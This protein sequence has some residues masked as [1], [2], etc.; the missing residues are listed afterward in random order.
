M[1][2]QEYLNKVFKDSESAFM[3]LPF[4]NVHGQVQ[5]DIGNPSLKYFLIEVIAVWPLVVPYELMCDVDREDLC[6]TVFYPD[7][8]LPA[9]F[10]KRRIINHFLIGCFCVYGL[11]ELS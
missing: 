4:R 1:S 10:V 6:K 5:L 2:S 3:T 8:N 9:D 11:R 7:P